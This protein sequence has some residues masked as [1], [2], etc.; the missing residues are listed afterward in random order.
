MK[1]V[2]LVL[3]RCY[4]SSIHSQWC[5]RLTAWIGPQYH[6]LKWL[7]ALLWISNHTT[8]LKWVPPNIGKR[9]CPSIVE[10]SHQTPKYMRI[11]SWI[12]GLGHAPYP[13][14]STSFHL[15]GRLKSFSFKTQIVSDRP[16]V[17]ISV[18]IRQHGHASTINVI[19]CN[20]SQFSWFQM[21]C[22][23]GALI[24]PKLP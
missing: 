4:L 18:W 19:F 10:P 11:F 17:K 12:F 8:T 5:L 16:W 21:H 1:V 13:F 14:E 15:H 7:Y 3:Y 6:H 2:A 22:E 20:Y 9:C 23:M 24:N